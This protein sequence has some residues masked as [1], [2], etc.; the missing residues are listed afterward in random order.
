MWPLEA[1][2]HEINDQVVTAF[3]DCRKTHCALAMTNTNALLTSPALPM[4]EMLLQC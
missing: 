2:F 1:A 4:M 3:Y